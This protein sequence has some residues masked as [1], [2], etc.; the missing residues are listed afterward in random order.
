MDL[1]EFAVNPVTLSLL[2]LFIVE[3]IKELGLR[4]NKLRIASL[5]VGFTLALAFKMRLVYPQAALWIDI[6]FFGLAAGLGAS[7]AYHLVDQRL[8]R[9][10]G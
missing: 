7:G 4:G 9:A 8:P 2:I 1:V 6:A 5:A 3:F 10:N